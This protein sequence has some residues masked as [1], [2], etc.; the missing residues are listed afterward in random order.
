M[1]EEKPKYI[2]GKCVYYKPIELENPP[3]DFTPRGWCHF[4]PPSVYP[5]PV[6]QQSRLAIASGET[7]PGSSQMAP[8]TIRPL[9]LEEEFICGQFIPDHAFHDEFPE[10]T[11]EQDGS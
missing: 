11:G 5:M 2:C 8:Y 7:A 4:M 3:K 10:I 6:Q 9:L 1:S